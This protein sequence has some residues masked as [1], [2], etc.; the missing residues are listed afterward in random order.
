MGQ[1]V[2]QPHDRYI[3]MIMM[4]KFCVGDV[5]PEHDEP[6]LWICISIFADYIFGVFMFLILWGVYNKFQDLI[7]PC[8]LFTCCCSFWQHCICTHSPS[9]FPY[10][11]TYWKFFSYRKWW[12][13]VCVK[14]WTSVTGLQWRCWTS[15]QLMCFHGW[16]SLCWTDIPSYSQQ[17]FTLKAKT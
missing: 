17:I 6:S 4:M 12:A 1:Q 10:F 7:L 11:V 16:I 5:I 8:I 15:S 9:N 2:V 3:M 14:T 13:A